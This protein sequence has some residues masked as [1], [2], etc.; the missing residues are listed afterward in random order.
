MDAFVVAMIIGAIII[1]IVIGIVIYVLFFSKTT[2]TPPP[3]P[4]VQCSRI[5]V[6]RDHPVGLNG[7]RIVSMSP[8]PTDDPPGP[9]FYGCTNSTS[10][11][12]PVYI[13]TNGVDTK[14][15]LTYPVSGYTGASTPQF[16]IFNTQVTGTSPLFNLT[17]GG[18]TLA[19]F[20]NPATID[21][22]LYNTG[23]IIG[24]VYPSLRP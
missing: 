10:L 2:P 11:N 20:S 14:L 8:S 23:S 1:L 9:Y 4:V 17:S 3:P 19:S 18:Y 24:Y 12:S 13:V 6:Y 22:F 21:G 16:Y 5:P 15:S 7:T